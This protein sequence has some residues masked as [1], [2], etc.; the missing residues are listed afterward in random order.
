MHENVEWDENLPRLDSIHGQAASKIIKTVGMRPG[1]IISQLEH[2]LV[3]GSKYKAVPSNGII[4]DGPHHFALI[5]EQHIPGC[6]E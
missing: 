6:E 4:Q 1:D 2:F 3:A 5:R